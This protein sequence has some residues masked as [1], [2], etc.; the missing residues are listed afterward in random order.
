MDLQP[1]IRNISYVPGPTNVG[2]IIQGN[3][4]ILIDSG[5]DESY[6]RKL[7]KLLRARHL[8]LAAIVHTHAHADHYGGDAYL[9]QHTQATV[10][11]PPLEE[12]ILRYPILEPF[13]LYGATPITELC[14]KHFMAAASRVDQIYTE[15]FTIAGVELKPVPLPGHSINQM[16]LQVGEVFFCADVVFPVRVLEKYKIIYCFDPGKQ[17]DTLRRLLTIPAQYYVPFHGTVLTEIEEVVR[18]N[19]A[20]IDH[21]EALLLHLLETPRQTEDLLAAVAEHLGLNLDTGQY[22][23]TLATIKAHLSALKQ[24]GQLTLRIHQNRLFWERV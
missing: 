2:V 17:R 6:G 16:G 9:L 12:A 5:L 11:A 15:Q 19:L 10:Y 7:L 14:T 13:Y 21:L 24:A 20:S 23:L 18:Q 1:I 4:A 22:F 8:E 3:Q